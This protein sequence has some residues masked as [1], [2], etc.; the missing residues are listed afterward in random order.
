MARGP[1]VEL[2][3]PVSG[4]HQLRP[5]AQFFQRLVADHH[6]DGGGRGGDDARRQPFGQTPAA[7][8][9]DQLPERLDDRAPAFHLDTG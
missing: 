4:V 7:F 5:Q 9:F 6:D 3:L 1:I 2:L 8:L